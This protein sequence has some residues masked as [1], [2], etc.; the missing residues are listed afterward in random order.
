MI[1]PIERRGCCGMKQVSRV[2]ARSIELEKNIPVAAGLGGGSSDAAAA[3]R[4]LNRFWRLG[5]TGRDLRIGCGLAAT[6]PSS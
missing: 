2:W 4:G 6:F 3:L 1:W 5:F